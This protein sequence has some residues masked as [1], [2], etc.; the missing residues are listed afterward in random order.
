MKKRTLFVF[1]TAVFVMAAC[2]ML[3]D[4]SAVDFKMMRNFSDMSIF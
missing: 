3:K 2:K 1:L 4:T